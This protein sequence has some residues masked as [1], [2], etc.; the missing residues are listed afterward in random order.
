[1]F[2]SVCSLG[3]AGFGAEALALRVLLP[4]SDHMLSVRTL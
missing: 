2:A 3:K 4:T 1:M